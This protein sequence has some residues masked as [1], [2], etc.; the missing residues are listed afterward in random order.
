MLTAR[1]SINIVIHYAQ[2]AID[3]GAILCPLQSYKEAQ[4]AIDI[5]GII[6]KLDLLPPEVD[7]EIRSELER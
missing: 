3:M 2:K 6:A 7:E 4:T 1:D 5:A